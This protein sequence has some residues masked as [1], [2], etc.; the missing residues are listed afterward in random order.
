MERIFHFLPPTQ[1]LQV[2][3]SDRYLLVTGEESVH[4][5]YV[6]GVAPCWPSRKAPSLVS[7][8][9]NLGP[10][11]AMCLLEASMGFRYHTKWGFTEHCV[12][13]G[14]VSDSSILL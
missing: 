8:Q 7:T 9:L 3:G 5:C 14:S 13:H 2:M 1:C 6:T 11:V 10:S 12:L 4:A